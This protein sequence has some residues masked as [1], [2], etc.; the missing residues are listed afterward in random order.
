[1]ASSVPLS[2]G[3]PHRTVPCGLVGVGAHC[4]RAYESMDERPLHAVAHLIHFDLI[5]LIGLCRNSVRFEAYYT[6]LAS[7]GKR[8][9]LH[10]I[11]H[12]TV[13]TGYLREWR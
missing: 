12:C 4:S 9:N 6:I 2:P 7:S 5:M 1:M 13:K 8:S 10:G 11:M 3:S